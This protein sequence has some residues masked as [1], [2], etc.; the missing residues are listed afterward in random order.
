MLLLEAAL[1]RLVQL[2]VGRFQLRPLC[3]SSSSSKSTRAEVRHLA[4]TETAPEIVVQDAST[5]RTLRFL[6]SRSTDY[7]RQSQRETCYKL[8]TSRF[9]RLQAIAP[10]LNLLA[11]STCRIARTSVGRWVNRGKALV[12][13]VLRTCTCHVRTCTRTAHDKSCTTD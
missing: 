13:R 12:V 1:A 9:L 5:L 3:S 2:R 10:R 6:R 7:A 8:T 4:E 11:V